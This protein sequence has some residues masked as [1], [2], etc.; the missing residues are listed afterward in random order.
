M[1]LLLTRFN[2]LKIAL[3]ISECS[4]KAFVVP[5]DKLLVGYHA[6]MHLTPSLATP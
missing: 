1:L 6:F 4:D 5:T 2:L 3:Y